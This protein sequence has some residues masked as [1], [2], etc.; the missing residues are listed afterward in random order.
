MGVA[1]TRHF[2]LLSPIAEDKNP[3]AMPDYKTLI[4]L[5][6][7]ASGT[8]HPVTLYLTKP[9]A[10]QKPAFR[11]LDEG[12]WAVEAGTKAAPAGGQETDFAVAIVLIGKS[13]A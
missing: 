7:K 1:P 6:R 2:F 13:E 3:A 4:A 10:G 11:S 5:S 9:S 12:H 8:N